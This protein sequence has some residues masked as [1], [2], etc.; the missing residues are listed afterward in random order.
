MNESFHHLVWQ[1]ATKDT[2]ISTIQTKFA[3]HIAVILF[4]EGYGS[5]LSELY[6]KVGITIS[7][8]ME[9]QWSQ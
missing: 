7:K 3:L 4:N 1:L 5:G 9:N 2:F 6:S 8:S